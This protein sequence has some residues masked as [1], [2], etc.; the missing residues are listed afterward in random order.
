LT[1]GRRLAEARGELAQASGALRPALLAARIARSR[2][3][4]AAA[5]LRP[6]LVTSRIADAQDRLARLWRVAEQLHPDKPLARGYARVEGREGK[7]VS[8]ASAARAAGAVT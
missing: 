5:R 7:T 2:E 3:R 8:T 1:L 4:L 6:A